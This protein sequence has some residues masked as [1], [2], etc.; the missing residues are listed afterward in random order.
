MARL[1][2]GFLILVLLNSSKATAQ[3][4][5]R[6]KGD[7]SFQKISLNVLPQNFYNQHLG[8]FCKKEIQMQRLTSLPLY[9]RLGSK[10]YVDGLEGKLKREAP[11]GKHESFILNRK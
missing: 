3:E 8:F 10:E 7:S 11:I 1:V 2:V 5:F 4:G 9:F 6:R